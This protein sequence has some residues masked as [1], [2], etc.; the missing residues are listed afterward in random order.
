MD[1]VHKALHHRKTQSRALLGI[2]GGE[3]G[4]HGLGHIGNAHAAVCDGDADGAALIEN[5]RH[6]DG[7]HRIGIGVNNAIGDSLRHG[8]LDIRQ[9]GHRGV[10]LGKKRRQSRAGKPFV[11]AT[12]GKGEFDLIEHF[13]GTSPD[14]T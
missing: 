1:L 8:G 7:A 12:A 14:H 4:F 3:H 11:D 10:R 13:H 2:A 9:L 6:G 5:R